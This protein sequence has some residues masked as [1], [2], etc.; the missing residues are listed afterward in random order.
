MKPIIA[1]IRHEIEENGQL[2]TAIAQLQEFR[3]HCEAKDFGRPPPFLAALFELAAGRPFETAPGSFV[4][5]EGRADLA[6]RRGGPRLPVVWMRIDTDRGHLA[7]GSGRR[8]CLAE[9]LDAL[10]PRL[11]ARLAAGE[12]LLV[13]DW[14]HEAPGRFPT[15]YITR[16][17][18]RYGI[19][20][21]AIAILTQSESP[22]LVREPGEPHIV[23]A[24]APAA[25]M[26][27][28]L[29]S[30]VRIRPGEFRAPFGFAA[31]G[32][33]AR[34]HRYVFDA[35]EASAHRALLAARL[36]E[37][38]EPGLIAFR[39]DAFRHNMPGSAPFRAAIDAVSPFH[40]RGDN[41]ALVEAFLARKAN[42]V[43]PPP[44]GEDAR[45]AH[46][47]LPAEALA[48]AMLTIV[49]DLEM[50]ADDASALST[51]AL[52]AIV[53]GLPFVVFGAPGTVAL[54][55]ETGFDVLDDVIDHGYDA[56]PD[57]AA[58]FAAAFEALEAFL[59]R[60]ASFAVD[61]QDRLVNAAA[62]NRRVFQGALLG[63]LVAAPLEHLGACHPRRARLPAAGLDALAPYI[64]TFSRIAP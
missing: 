62:H 29:F 25:T 45:E 55:A 21:A 48:R 6:A 14:S 64:P 2:R 38:P 37:R 35:G 19:A 57:P 46:R 63:R 7:L 10:E 54:L 1:T 9:R 44:P 47:F 49:A 8:I 30:D 18:E 56:E 43:I 50:T 31:A 52:K 17:A 27:R 60:P 24:H 51:D 13:L 32:P 58:R 40:E 59:D 15:A 22:V 23:T 12:A 3:I 20:P 16:S 53:T 41:L 28:L 11:L 26:W 42:L 61:E 33:R 39:K 36:V 4:R 34:P 5:L